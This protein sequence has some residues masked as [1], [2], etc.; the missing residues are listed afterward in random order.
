MPNEKANLTFRSGVLIAVAVIVIGIFLYV[1]ISS[2]STNKKTELLILSGAGLIKPMEE[3]AKEFANKNNV[4]IN[5][6]YGG[7][8]ELMGQ[9]SLG[10]AGDIFI[11]GAEKYVYD[12]DKNGWIKKHTITKLVKHIPVIAIPYD[13]PKNINNINDLGSEGISLALGDENACAIGKI[14]KK[15]IKKSW[16]KEQIK[17]NTKVYAPTVNQLLMYVVMKQVDATIIWKDMLTWAESHQSLKSI[18]I[19]PSLNII[20]TIAAGV[21]T[22]SKHQKLS[23]QMVDFMKS[24]EGLKI[25]E[26][27]GFEP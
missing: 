24:P 8:G 3:I 6:K 2:S 15:I 26:K 10:Q 11:P 18:E 22:Y 7:S 14:S 19:D 13:N 21:T 23:E 27:W 20:K 1:K 12:A 5:V 9:L 16:V 25:W 4:I 17:T